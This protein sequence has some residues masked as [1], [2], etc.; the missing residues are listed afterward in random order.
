MNRT[1]NHII[2][3]ESEHLLRGTVPTEWVVRK[4]SPD[5]AID[6][7]VEVFKDS[8]ATGEHFFIQ[9]KGT[10]KSDKQG[11]ISYQLDRK[12]IEY[13]AKLS[14]PILLVYCS[15]KSRK[16][17]GKWM[18]RSAVDEN[19]K[20]RIISFSC[21]DILTIDKFQTIVKA[22]STNCG[23]VR[24]SYQDNINDELRLF[25]TR[26]IRRL[27]GGDVT[28]GDNDIADELIVTCDTTRTLEVKI[29]DERFLAEIKCSIPES[30]TEDILLIPE[31]DDIPQSLHGFLYSLARMLLERNSSNALCLLRRLLPESTTD[32]FE[33]IF[34]IVMKSVTN[35]E[36]NELEELGK[37]AIDKEC[38][39][40]YQFLNLFLLKYA[41]D[42]NIDRI[43]ES[44]LVYAIA[45]ATDTHFTGM[46]HYNLAN[47]YQNTDRRR[48]AIKHY[49]AAKRYEPDYCNK[50]YWARELAGMFFL[51]KRYSASARMYELCLKSDRISKEPLTFA[52]AAD[53]HFMARHLSRSLTLFQQ[54]TEMVEVPDWEFILKK[55]TIK[56]ISDQ[57]GLETTFSPSRAEKL[58]ITLENAEELTS[59]IKLKECLS[60][61]PLC[62]QACFQMAVLLNDEEKFE[63]ACIHYLISALVTEWNVPAWLNSFFM[64]CKTK[65]HMMPIILNVAYKKCGYKLIEV[66]RDEIVKRKE[67]PTEIKTQTIE[68]LRELFEE[69]KKEFDSVG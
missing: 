47:H 29:K 8:Q 17:W 2:E 39:N 24:I 21:T 44:L 23:P 13:Y 32:N 69:Y 42:K 62:P 65:S 38:W 14:L 28:E 54:Y 15:V 35:K 61:D 4:L 60:L 16:L 52:L 5:Y 27:F 67:I 55:Q 10:D 57:F 18:N 20:S 64:A 68:T 7:L 40:T 26:W 9:L 25:L 41:T 48:E 46:L 51:E 58:Y 1:R 11:R 34:A 3:D 56:T 50:D 45:G 19:A 53:A 31:V 6:Y 30:Y 59:A 43:K 63:E 22:L 36:Y 49:L 33:D 12:Y 37:K 66:L